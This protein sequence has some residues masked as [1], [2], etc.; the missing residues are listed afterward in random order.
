MQDAF[1]LEMLPPSDPRHRA[2][3]MIPQ[4]WACNYVRHSAIAHS[5]SK[6]FGVGSCRNKKKSEGYYSSE[7]GV[8][9]ESEESCRGNGIRRVMPHDMLG[10]VVVH[11][12]LAAVIGFFDRELVTV[13]R[14]AALF[15]EE[16]LGALDTTG[17]PG[18]ARQDLCRDYVAHMQS[19]LTDGE[20]NSRVLGG[21][22]D[23]EFWAHGRHDR[24]QYWRSRTG[25]LSQRGWSSFSERR[26]W[27][28]HTVL[29]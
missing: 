24:L 6:K 18:F 12:M 8:V 5:R 19:L 20:Q 29:Q 22:R 15:A 13:A 10:A 26:I 4:A 7:N 21:G 3:V 1:K 2:I 9:R 25:C 23:A 28:P 27:D 17:V 16:I 14:R 11:D